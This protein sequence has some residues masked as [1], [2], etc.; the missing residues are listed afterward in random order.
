[1]PLKHALT[2]LAL[3]GLLAL[4]QP[5]LSAPAKVHT[6]KPGLWQIES[7]T[8]LHGHIVPDMGAL[9]ELGP[10]ALQNHVQNMLRQNHMRIAE[11]GTATICVTAEQIAQNNFVNDQGSGCT[12]GAGQRKGNNIRFDMRCD[13]PKGGGYTNVTVI[14]ATKWASYSKMDLTVRKMNQNIVNQSFG[15]WVSETCPAGQ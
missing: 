13:A 2:S 6:L 1:M 8:W 7:Q 15:T 10:V 4:C 14:N 9:I 11:N 5:A 3:T 12:V